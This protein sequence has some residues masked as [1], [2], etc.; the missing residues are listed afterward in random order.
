MNVGF[1]A[2]SNALIALISAIIIYILYP[3]IKSKINESEQKKLENL[4]NIAVRAAEQIFITN[5]NEDHQDINRTK[6]EY[7]I[8]WLK[9]NGV[10]NIN[11]ETL[12]AII[13]SAVYHLKEISQ[14]IN[15]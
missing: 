11:E 12:D 5:E 15:E 14:K 4:V 13:E 9:A 10:N 8:N 3:F 1:L 2:I 6:K 7:V